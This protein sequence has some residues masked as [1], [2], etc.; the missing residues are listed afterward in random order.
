M[1]AVQRE[2]RE[3]M[4]RTNKKL[5][6]EYIQDQIHH[7]ESAK[8]RLADVVEFLEGEFPDAP[9]LQELAKYA[10]KLDQDYKMWAKALEVLNAR[11]DD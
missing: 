8:L 4:P 2:Y 10:E 9:I 1:P 6:S 11:H 5:V 3:R 7:F